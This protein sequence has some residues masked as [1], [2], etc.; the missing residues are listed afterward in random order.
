MSFDPV[1]L[2]SSE[3]FTNGFFLF[4]KILLLIRIF[5]IMKFDCKVV[6][7]KISMDDSVV[8]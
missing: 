3:L 8:S 1:I 2:V 4:A 5:M 7:V 6:P